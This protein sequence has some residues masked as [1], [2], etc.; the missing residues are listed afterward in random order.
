MLQETSSFVT[1]HVLQILMT[2]ALVVYSTSKKKLTLDG[3]VA[4][5][6]TATVHMLHPWS[7]FFYLLVTFF[8]AGTLATKVRLLIISVVPDMHRQ[9]PSQQDG[10][11]L[12]KGP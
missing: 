8:M 4:A 1:T 2:I 9:K 12:E 10:W 11:E 6:L 7:V 3:V 5:V